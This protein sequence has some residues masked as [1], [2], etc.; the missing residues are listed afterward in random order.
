MGNSGGGS[1]DQN[2]VSNVDTKS[3]VHE[4]STGNKD[5]IGKWT[6]GHTCFILAKNLSSFCPSPNT[7]YET[8]FKGGWN[9]NV[10]EEV[11]RPSNVQA[12]A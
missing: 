6:S 4:V 11:S 3:Q 8:E 7:S 9:I 10:M 5:S 1:E 12:V 2:A